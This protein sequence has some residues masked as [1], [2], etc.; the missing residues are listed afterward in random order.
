MVI[1]GPVL[2]EVI[3]PAVALTH[4]GKPRYIIMRSSFK[5]L[6]F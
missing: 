3:I 2:F 5:A 6:T 1:G 4:C